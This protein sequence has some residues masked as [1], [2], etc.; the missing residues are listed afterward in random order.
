MLE[1]AMKLNRE[2]SGKPDE[3]IDYATFLADQAKKVINDVRAIQTEVFKRNFKDYVQKAKGRQGYEVGEYVL[4]LFPRSNKLDVEWKGPFLVISKE[5]NGLI[6]V[7]RDLRNGEDTRRAEDCGVLERDRRAGKLPVPQVFGA[8]R[9]RQSET[10]ATREMLESAEY[11]LRKTGGGTE[12][13]G[14]D[15]LRHQA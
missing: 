15:A 6:Y 12:Q 5:D 10:P 3:A 1:A 11:T 2:D 13:H 8:Y 14:V 9:S 7:V 4:V